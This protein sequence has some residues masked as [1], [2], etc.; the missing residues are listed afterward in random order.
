MEGTGGGI[1]GKYETGYTVVI[2]EE[3]RKNQTL[4]AHYSLL[5]DLPRQCK[6]KDNVDKGTNGYD[7]GIKKISLG[8]R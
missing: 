8:I 5:I 7:M 1:A 4:Q 3:E 6:T 2:Q